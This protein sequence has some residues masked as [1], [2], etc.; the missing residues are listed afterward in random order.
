MINGNDSNG[1][2]NG[3]NNVCVIMRGAENERKWYKSKQYNAA[4]RMIQRAPQSTKS[5]METQVR[6]AVGTTQI[7]QNESESRALHRRL[8]RT[9][10]L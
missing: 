1:S 10:N 7:E 8:R 3:D 4:T 6:N 9:H 2:G 5:W